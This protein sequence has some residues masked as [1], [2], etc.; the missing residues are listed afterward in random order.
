MSDSDNGSADSFDDEIDDF[1]VTTPRQ[2]AGAWMLATRKAS[3]DKNIVTRRL[4]SDSVNA[5][6]SDSFIDRD[7]EDELPSP[8]HALFEGIDFENVEKTSRYKVFVPKHSNYQENIFVTQLTQPPSPPE[9]IRGPRWK[10]PDP[11]PPTPKPP[12][13]M[14]I[15]ASRADQYRDDEKEIEAAIAASLRSFEEENCGPTSAMVDKSSATRTAAV[16]SNA[17]KQHVADVPFDVDD[18]PDDAFD[19]DLS[20][21]P[22]RSNS[23]AALRGPVQSQFSTNRPLGLR[24]ST[25]FGMT[26]RASEASIPRGEQVFSPPDKNEA[27]THH[28]LDEEALNTWIY[29]TNLGKTRDY[30]FN[31][32]QRGL[33]H[34]LLVALPTGLGKTFIAATIMLNWYRWTKSSQI[35]FVAPTKPLVSQQISACFGIAGIPRS[36]TTMLTGEAAP[37]IRAEEWK[38]K[39]VFFMTPQTLIND[40]KSGIADPKRIVLLVVDEA[41][42][43]TGGYAYV[44]VVKFIKRYNKSFRVLALT[45]TPGSTVE[46]VQAVIDGLDIAKVE[47]R[48][49][50]SLDIREYVHARNTDVQTFQNSDEM[51]LCMDLFSR[52]LQPLVDQLCSLNAYW[53]KDPMALT[54]FGLTKARQQWMLSDAGRNANYGLKGKVNAI[55]TVLASLAHAIDLLK[56]HGITPFYRHLVHFRSNT[57]GQKGGKYQRQIVQDES[58]K[59]LMNHLQPWTKNPEFIGH[60]KLEYLKQVVLNHFMDA[61][62]GS[63]ADGNHTRSATRIMVFA[64][65]RDSAEEIVRVLKRY[66]PLIRPHVFVGQSSAK[67][68]EGMDQKTQLSIVQKFKKGDYNTIVATSIGEEGLDI[69]E[70]DLIVCYDSSAS[71]IR[72]LQ[73]MG[74]TGRKRAGNIVLLLMQGKEEESYIRAKDNY[75]KMQEMIASGTRFAFHDDT[76]PRI[77]PPGIRPT[78]DKKQIDIP[79]ENTQADLPEPKR[80]ARPPKRPPKKFHMPDDVETGFSKASSLTGNKGA[81]K[82][83]KQTT[84]RKPTPEPVAIPALE[85][86][87]LTPSQQNDLERRY[88]HIGGTS[89]QFIRNPRVDA[90]PRLQSVPR[91]TRAVKHGALTSRMIGTLQKMHQVGADCES[92][93]KD[94]LAL[95]SSKRP[96]DSVL[97]Q[98]SARPRQ[99]KKLSVGVSRPSKAQPPQTQSTLA[100]IREGLVDDGIL[101]PTVPNELA[102]LL[103]H[104][105]PKPFY[106]SQISQDDLES[107]FD[108]PD[109]DTL[110]NRNAERTTPRKRNRFV[111]GDDSDE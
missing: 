57:D 35:I 2:S 95:E 82:T 25:L 81:K 22:P 33:F 31:I 72:M 43:A 68:S 18:I 63:G 77:L 61:G 26:A 11:E 85:E 88:C 89:P 70:V 86:V 46:S 58:F 52:T 47:I 50:Q 32:T 78:A 83:D 76:S 42:R 1:V 12:A 9:M 54:P 51:V 91:P 80:R 10:K 30:Q 104:Q 65:F 19:S 38:A 16:P 84:I 21:S 103:G 74:R 44:E 41:H 66:E 108:L 96:E 111:L 27:P 13:T 45:A 64:H 73:R 107:D 34:N 49:E 8:D 92:R 102:S 94:I 48:T 15:P 98:E 110:I 62:E 37:G 56:Y 4:E 28:K 67:G 105:N 106:S 100:P 75:E 69:G 17:Q 60:P 39:R 6:G 36:Q 40:L 53:G 97:V 55:F 24:Q 59:K 87:L 7:E 109:F 23:Q 20:L 90:Y 5:L 93:Y 14:T 99:N 71:P 101:E 79:V 3:Y 29:P